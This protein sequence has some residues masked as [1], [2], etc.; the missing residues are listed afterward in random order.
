MEELVEAAGHSFQRR[1]L[2]KILRRGTKKFL[3]T[4]A[5]GTQTKGGLGREKK[6][7]NRCDTPLSKISRVRNRS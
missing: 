2:H 7:I 1:G 4:K 6:T 3:G 5:E